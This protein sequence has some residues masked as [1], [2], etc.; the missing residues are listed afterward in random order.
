MDNRRVG[1]GA[2]MYFPVE[3]RLLLVPSAAY[4]NPRAAVR[5]PSV[6][7]CTA[8][9]AAQSDRFQT[10]HAAKRGFWL[11]RFRHLHFSQTTL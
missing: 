1:K 7:L 11:R 5:L 10:G 4:C 3:V 2:T 9:G 8:C 6:P